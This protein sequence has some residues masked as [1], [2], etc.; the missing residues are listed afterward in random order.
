MKKWKILLST[1][2]L[3][4]ILS[5]TLLCMKDSFLLDWWKIP[6]I[7]TRSFFIS[8]FIVAI[9]QKKKTAITGILVSVLGT[10]FAIVSSQAII[11]KEYVT[12]YNQVLHM[13]NARYLT[14]YRYLDNLRPETG[15]TFIIFILALFLGFW[16]G[17]F[18]VTGKFRT[19]S[20]LPIPAFIVIGL[21]LGYA[22]SVRTL[23][24]LL[25]GSGIWYV[26][27]GL[28]EDEAIRKEKILALLCMGAA[29]LCSLIVLKP[30]STKLLKYSREWMKFQLSLE[31][32]VLAFADGQGWFPNYFDNRYET[33]NKV[34]LSNQKPRLTDEDMF[35]ITIS[36]R[37]I[38]IIYM[39]KF[40][41][42]VYQNGSWESVEG[43][44]EVQENLDS[45]Y[46]SFSVFHETTLEM[47][48]ELL[49]EK[50]NVVLIPYGQQF[51]TVEQATGA[52]Y[53]NDV[54]DNEITEPYKQL[55]EG[56]LKRLRDA[57][58]ELMSDTDFNQYE[59]YNNLEAFI[60]S[61]EFYSYESIIQYDNISGTIILQGYTLESDMVKE[62]IQKDTYYSFDLKPVPKEQDFAEYFLFE[63]K[64]GFCVHYATTGTLLLRAMG[65][66]SR[67]ASGY[68]IM[69]SDFEEN[70]D[71]SFTAVVKKK[72]AH[73]WTEVLQGGSLRL[74]GVQLQWEPVEMTPP[75]YINALRREDSQDSLE[76]TVGGVEQQMREENQK[77]NTPKQEEAPKPE[78][79]TESEPI[80]EKLADEK[81]FY[82]KD[83]YFSRAVKMVLLLFGLIFVLMMCLLLRRVWILSKRKKLF[84][85]GEPKQA[86]SDITKETLR[87][88]K[89]LGYEKDPA[90]TEL[91][92]G[93]F[94][95]K[96]L[97][98][99]WEDEF[100]KFITIARLNTYGNE[101][102]TEEQRQHMYQVY[103]R[104]AAFAKTQGKAGKRLYWKYVSLIL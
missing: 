84:L 59:W 32:T 40:T 55:P 38:S 23:L 62:F 26:S 76:E 89:A 4:C 18:F 5:G 6:Y 70:E 80:Q 66:P 20:L 78:N 52:V 36:E 77:E 1:I 61:D 34:T 2:C 27:S 94:V 101:V 7:E 96:R 100:I 72:R 93:I 90:V 75:A 30:T 97:D 60:V 45:D 81:A 44:E 57:A 104:I 86:V 15:S 35:R 79:N 71:G 99:I 48:L 43:N 51:H 22:P 85:N 53:Y 17:I 39:K 49:G 74:W 24:L 33:P 65:I 12:L 82:I 28:T 58:Q 92:Y 87:I 63:Q 64:K 29:V 42:E 67:Y 47:E 50:E 11:L 25:A 10:A 73:A 69:P 83:S 56:Q 102:I 31:D 98:C 54:Y 68:I 16:L 14:D 9:Y 13:I 41:G 91:D 3:W 8:C 46:S 21:L 19:I 103:I 95:Q 88:L 37:P